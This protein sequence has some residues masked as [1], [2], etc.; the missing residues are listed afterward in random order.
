MSDFVPKTGAIIDQLHRREPLTEKEQ[1]FADWAA[2]QG[3]FAVFGKAVPQE[4]DEDF[5]P[6]FTYELGIEEMVDERLMAQFRTVLNADLPDMHP[7][8]WARH[9]ELLRRDFEQTKAAP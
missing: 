9:A 6:F 8:E 7:E 2:E 5:T 4:D 1:R 3:L